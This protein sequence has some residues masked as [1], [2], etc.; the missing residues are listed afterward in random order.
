M[1]IWSLGVIAVGIVSFVIALA[2]LVDMTKS[3]ETDRVTWFEGGPTIMMAYGLLFMTIDQATIINRAA[4]MNGIGT[5]FVIVETALV[6]FVA[7]AI[8][9]FVT[10]K[11]VNANQ[12]ETL[13]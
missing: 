2:C 12:G 9:R 8:T 13:E 6:T 4:G 10:G 11:Y 7:A 3:G 1:N 5:V